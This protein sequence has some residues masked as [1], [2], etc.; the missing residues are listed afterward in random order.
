MQAAL[1]SLAL[2]TSLAAAAQDG[3]ALLPP[4]GWRSWNQFQSTATQATMMSAFAAL[5]D[6][7]RLVNGAPTSL[8]E[9]GYSDAGID[10]YWQLCGSY[11]PSNYTYHTATGEPVVD[12]AK[13]PNM[14]AMCDA[15]HALN[16]TCGWYGNNCGCHD[17]CT[18]VAC[19]AGDI[20]AAIAFGFDSW[21]LDGCGAEENVELFYTASTWATKKAGRKPFL[22][23]NCHNGPNEPTRSPDWQ[24]FHFYRA[25]TDIAPTWGSILANVN[26]MPRLAAANLSFPGVWAYP[27]M[28]EVGITLAQNMVSSLENATGTTRFPAHTHGAC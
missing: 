4:M 19:F 1:L 18:D 7:S 28:L 23:E 21:K 20:N 22:I 8:A 25:S 13:F 16:L 17:H 9:L 15:A 14:T 24:P 27:D 6:R 12:L 3:L 26:E 10:D 2:S 11:G 5:G